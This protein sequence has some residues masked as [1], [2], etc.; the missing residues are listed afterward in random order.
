VRAFVTKKLFLFGEYKYFVTNYSWG[1]EG[2]ST[3]RVKLDF[4][5]QIVSGGIGWSF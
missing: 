5:T 1:S 2:A 3:Q 4:Q